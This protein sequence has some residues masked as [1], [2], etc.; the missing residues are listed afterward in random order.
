MIT[1]TENTTAGIAQLKA[2]GLKK[3]SEITSITI[4]IVR[5]LSPGDDGIFGDSGLASG[6][7]R[8]TCTTTL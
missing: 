7:V 2:S 1:F 3:I 6:S 4:P 8:Q 5:C